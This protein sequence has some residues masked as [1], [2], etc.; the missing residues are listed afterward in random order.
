MTG[1]RRPTNI[2][3]PSPEL[4]NDSEEEEDLEAE[5]DLEIVKMTTLMQAG[6]RHLLHERSDLMRREIKS[7][8]G[9]CV[10]LKRRGVIKMIYKRAGKMP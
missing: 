1:S 5:E 6:Q 8:H 4:N 3:P 10:N 9:G 2:P 7:S